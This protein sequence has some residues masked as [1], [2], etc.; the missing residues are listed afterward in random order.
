[1]AGREDLQG[2]QGRQGRRALQVL[3]RPG[4]R[5]GQAV[6]AHLLGMFHAFCSFGGVSGGQSASKSWE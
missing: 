2:R 5:E 3:L 1:V 4:A 6:E